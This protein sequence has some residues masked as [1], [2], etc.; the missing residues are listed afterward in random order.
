LVARDLDQRLHILLSFP[1]SRTMSAQ[2]RVS[3]DCANRWQQ[4]LR[5]LAWLVL[6]ASRIPESGHELT[7]SPHISVSS[8]SSV[9][10]IA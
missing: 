1:G 8:P 4:Y 3:H 2:I 6:I 9:A 7:S 5:T 10:N